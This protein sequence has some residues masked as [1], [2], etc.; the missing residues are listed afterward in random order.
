MPTAAKPTASTGLVYTA[1]VPISRTTVLRAAAFKPDFVAT[2][3]D[4]H[5]YIFTSDVISHPNMRT[6]ITQDAVYGPQMDASLK[7]VPIQPL[8]WISTNPFFIAILSRFAKP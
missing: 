3:V 6:S 2:N 1:P 4:T 7:S 8:F 5:T